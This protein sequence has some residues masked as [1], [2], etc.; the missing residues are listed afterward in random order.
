MQRRIAI[1]GAGISGLTAAGSF[2]QNGFT[3]TVFEKSRG[4]GGRM[5]TR[6]MDDISFD[7]GAQY[8][9]VKGPSFRTLVEQWQ[10]QGCAEQWFGEAYVG[11]P[12][13]TGPAQ[14]MASRHH[15]V[16]GA[17]ITAI[18]RSAGGWSLH[19]EN[20]PLQC[21][22]NG[23]FLAVVFA[24][25]A[26][27]IADIDGSELLDCD[28]TPVKFAPCWAL[29]LTFERFPQ[30][31]DGHLRPDDDLIG[32]IASN[33]TK[34]RRSRNLEN[35]VVH[36]TPDWS[37]ETFERPPDEVAATILKRLQKIT[38]FAATPITSMSHRWR[39]ALVERPLAQKCIWNDGNKLGACG[40]W[41]LGPRIEAAFDSGQA[42]A[43]AAC[44][45]LGKKAQN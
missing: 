3:I 34:P 31:P 18:E 11:T 26:P 27:Q 30:L 4:L 45:T 14:F 42:L 43:V 21:D 41:C 22:G 20:G 8:F 40:D 24:I 28:L 7:H 23:E 15:V 37:R 5:S 16:H 12:G 2:Q 13:M 19:S 1:V 35:I 10:A 32:W 6:R 38:R 29:M 39:Y 36:A 17:R 9:T 25:P 33:G 44:Q